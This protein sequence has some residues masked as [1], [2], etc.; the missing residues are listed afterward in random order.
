MDE[1]RAKKLVDMLGMKLTRL[2]R[3]GEGW[4]LQTLSG[5]NTNNFR[6]FSDVARHLDG[7]LME[8]AMMQSFYDELLEKS[9]NWHLEDVLRVEEWLADKPAPYPGVLRELQSISRALPRQWRSRAAA[10]CAKQLNSAVEARRIIRGETLA[11][12]Q[13]GRMTSSGDHETNSIRVT[14]PASINSRQA[15]P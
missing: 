7:T 2:P 6:H 8:V 3:D 5:G 4:Q 9:A 15:D 10:I 13:A 14:E 11:I 12:L 1:E